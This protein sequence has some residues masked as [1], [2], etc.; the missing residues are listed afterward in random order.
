[1]AG[2]TAMMQN[3]LTKLWDREVT[4]K[5]VRS[6]G[7]SYIVDDGNR[8][9]IRNI[10][11]LKHM[12]AEL[13][14]VVVAQSVADAARRSCLAHKSEATR[15]LAGEELQGVRKVVTWAHPLTKTVH[16]HRDG[17]AGELIVGLP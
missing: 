3:S 17:R 12:K 15:F 1:M 2:D 10:R 11:W 7:R 8:L 5:A 13:V 9:F 16:F 4:I 6:S 14:N